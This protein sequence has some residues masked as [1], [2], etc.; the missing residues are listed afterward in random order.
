MRRQTNLA[1][2]ASPASIALTSSAPHAQ[3]AEQPKR[4]NIVF[5]LI[6][7]MGRGEMGCY[8]NTFNETPRIDKFAASAERFAEAYCQA[9]CS[10][11]RASLMTGQYPHRTGIEDYLDPNSP[12]Y[13]DPKNEY[14]INRLLSD[15]GY[16][17]CNIGKW[18]LD[19][20]FKNPKGSSKQFGFDEVIG[21]ET[22]YIADANYFFPFGK[23]RTLPERSTHEFLPDRLSDET[24]GFIE[25]ASVHRQPF[26]LY[27]A[28]YAV[29]TDLDAPAEVV[30]NDRRKYEAKYGAGSSKKFNNKHI[31]PSPTTSTWPRWPSGWTRASAKSWTRS[32]GSRSP[33]TRSWFCSPTTVATDEWPTMASFAGRKG[34][35][36]KAESATLRSFAGPV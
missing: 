10:P 12:Q 35:S 32:T 27:Y 7:D 3:S 26:F 11:T 34:R 9:V 36:G 13:L 22:K 28:E 31:S 23:I 18:H 29:H 24:V 16:V 4:P 8:G 25:R 6:D 20:H 33:T 30:E 15:A 19:A 5:M 2:V 17:T 14:T 1:I 21:T